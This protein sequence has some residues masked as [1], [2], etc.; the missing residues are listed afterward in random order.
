[1][2]IQNLFL[3]MSVSLVITFLSACSS[4]QGASRGTVSPQVTTYPGSRVCSTCG[5]VQS[6]SPVSEDGG[7]TGAGV[8]IG[9]VLGG[10]AGNQV[11][12]GTGKDVAT[13]AGA[14]GGAL[15]GNTVEKN[16]NSN[17]WYDIVINMEDGSQRIISVEN[18]GSLRAGSSVNVQGN[19]IS[20]R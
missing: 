13:V 17:S 15:L 1:M 7:T 11:G 12:G 19:N 4:P 9:A 8:V 3:L 20:L 14:V 5:V 16:R 18:P 10:L 2:K 6:V